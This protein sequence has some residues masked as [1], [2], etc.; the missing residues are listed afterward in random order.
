M[1]GTD[2]TSTDPAE[3]RRE[4]RWRERLLIGLALASTTALMVAFRGTL[5]KAHF[6]LVYVLIVLGASALQGRRVGL[7]TSLAAF[8]CFDLFL[9]PPYNTLVVADPFDWLVLV[10]FMVV[11]AAAAQQL[12]RAQ[13]EAAA[14]RARA[15]EVGQLATL[16]AETLSAGRAEEA[17]QAIARAIQ[18]ALDVAAC[19]IH[20]RRDDG[21]FVR[22]G[23]EARAGTIESSTPEGE[24][25]LFPFVVEGDAIAV[26]RMDGTKSIVELTE[27]FLEDGIE[28]ALDT[29]GPVRALL[30]P[31]IVQARSV[32]LLRIADSSP[33][34]LTP[35][36]RR[37]AATLAYY[38]ALALERVRLSSQAEHASALREADRLKDA[39]LASVS[40]DLRTPLTT[41]KGLAHEMRL[42]GEARAAIVEEEADRL[43]SFVAGLLDLS[44]LDGNAVVVT[45]EINAADDLVGAALQQAAGVLGDREIRTVLPA[46]EFLL[47]RFDFVQSLRVLVNLLVNAHRYSPVSTPIDLVVE[48]SG[49]RLL[50][51]VADRG[52]GV[53]PDERERIFL[54]F[55]RSDST[56][57]SGG[58]GLGLPIARRLAEAQEGT[59][60]LSSREGGGSVFTF[61]VPAVDDDVVTAEGST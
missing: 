13:R 48:R 35:S 1:L 21:S 14:A 41:I 30:I 44:R 40:H 10:V 22:L 42:E 23:Y 27:N 18:Q 39:L 54:P 47:G 2:S 61:A 16:G 12:D 9:L 51:S 45:T 32:G 52:P 31:L 60:E 25:A 50:F 6:A 15:A 5:D 26:Q 29:G 7:I 34:A 33:L 38:A 36:A 53:P 3:S 46:S 57:Y 37:F 19:E 8:L 49:N 58:A 59:V 56:T 28:R 4:H 20:G 55:H 17:V 43:E 11:S 24:T